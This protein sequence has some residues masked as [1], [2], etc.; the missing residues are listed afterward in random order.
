MYEFVCKYCDAHNV[1]DAQIFPDSIFCKICNS[2]QNNQNEKNS[3][4]PTLTLRYVDSQ[5]RRFR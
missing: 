3:V 4:E 1:F 5:W 2:S